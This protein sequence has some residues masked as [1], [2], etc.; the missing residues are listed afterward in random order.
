MVQA[1]L[2]KPQGGREGLFRMLRKTRQV[3][4]RTGNE[5]GVWHGRPRHFRKRPQVTAAIEPKRLSDS[6]RTLEVNLIH[7]CQ[8]IIV[9][10]RLH[11]KVSISW[12]DPLKIEFATGGTTPF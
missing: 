12:L 9:K 10:Y 5:A 8:H 11:V 2:S 1:G 6:P 3:T 7:A 4:R